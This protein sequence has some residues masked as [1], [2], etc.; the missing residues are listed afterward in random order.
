MYR[1]TII[2]LLLLS[3][4]GLAAQSAPE[5][6]DNPRELGLRFSGFSDFNLFYKKGLGEQKYRRHRF[7]IGRIAYNT[8]GKDYDVNL[9]YAIGTEKRRA[10][11]K[12]LSFIHGW[13]YS[14][15][16]AYSN[17]E[18]RSSGRSSQLIAIPAIGYVLGFQLDVSEAFC[19]T[20]EV[21]PGLAGT[22]ALYNNS[23]NQY[24]IEANL[25]SNATALSLM[26][27]F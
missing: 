14:L 7:L 23:D 26:Y 5:P 4:A 24:K 25:N 6:S 10:I 16:L 20:A 15:S 18:N 11:A 21:I 9:G 12:N 19:I 8:N 2:L 22:A 17:A 27:R 13:E 3:S 1:T